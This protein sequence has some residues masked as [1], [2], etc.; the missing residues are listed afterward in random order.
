MGRINFVR[1]F[2]HNFIVMVKRIHNML[3]QDQYFSWTKDVE[4]D[5]VGIKKVIN[6]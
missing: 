2:V 6:L 3:E 5:F 4:R 1:R